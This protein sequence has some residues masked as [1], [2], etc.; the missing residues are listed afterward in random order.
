MLK[1]HLSPPTVHNLAR[2]MRNGCNRTWLQQQCR[3]KADLNGISCHTSCHREIIRLEIWQIVVL[4]M[5]LAPP[6]G[7]QASSH[8]LLQVLHVLFVAIL[9]KMKSHKQQLST[10]SGP[11]RSSHRLLS[12]LM[13]LA[14]STQFKCGEDVWS[15]LRCISFTRLWS[16]FSSLSPVLELR[17]NYGV[18]STW[19]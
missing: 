10:S 4:W 12:Q 15:W 9:Q 19:W 18:F 11:K 6:D 2:Y 1:L 13:Y 5:R 14:S 3:P 7:S 8:V 16:N 17:T